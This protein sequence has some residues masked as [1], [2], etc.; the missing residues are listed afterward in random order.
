MADL[1]QDQLENILSQLL[2]TNLHSKLLSTTFNYSQGSSNGPWINMPVAK[3]SF[4][5]GRT[6]LTRLNY[7]L[8]VMHMIWRLIRF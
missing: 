3:R 2:M 4:G 8:V 1:D 7:E 6:L 5:V